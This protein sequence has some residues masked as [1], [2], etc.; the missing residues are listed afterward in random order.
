MAH[1]IEFR[2]GKASMAW[3]GQTP[4]HGLGVKVDSDLTPNE[5][6]KAA[7]LD[8]KVKKLPLM[9][10]D[11]EQSIDKQL[12]RIP[13]NFALVR[14]VDQ[15]PMGV[16]SSGWEPNQNEDAF[17]FFHDFVK[18]GHMEMHTAG[19]LKN[20]KMVWALAKVKESFAVCKGKDRVD[21]Y[22]L[23]SNPH[24]YG[25]SI[26]IRF[27][28]IRVVCNNT[29]TFALQGNTDTMVRL[30]HRKKFDAEMV[31][32]TMGLAHKKLTGYQKIAEILTKARYTEDSVKK[33]LNE[34]LPASPTEKENE[35]GKLSRPASI[36]YSVLETQPGNEFAKGSWWQ[37]FNAVTFSVDHLLGHNPESRLNSAWYGTNRQKKAM[38]LS[39]AHEYA[40]A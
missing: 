2:N 3:V 38:A 40:T 9:C 37:A 33:F 25:K 24:E 32:Q 26:D 13:Q 31:K 36:A 18:E 34:V 16:I 28:P 21:S 15:Q 17:E 4:W 8:W 20:G 27:T 6:L 23:F 19:S 35:E 12:I 1:E 10:F 5:M 14:D 11:E 7:N 39:K 30:N 22:L 29:L